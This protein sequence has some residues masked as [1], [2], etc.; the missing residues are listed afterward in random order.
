[1]KVEIVERR[2]TTVWHICPIF[3]LNSD[4]LSTREVLLT[5]LN[6]LKQL[7]AINQGLK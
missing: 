7:I 4:S 2:F 3:S 6:I 5:P 1:M